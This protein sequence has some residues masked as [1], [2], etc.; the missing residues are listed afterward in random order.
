[1]STSVRSLAIA[2]VKSDVPRPTPEFLVVCRE[3]TVFKAIAA[4]IRKVNGRLNCA[5]GTGPALDYLLRRKIDGIVIDMNFPGA[6]DFI[7]R[8]RSCN[9][10][11][12]SVVFACMGALPETQCAFGA[13]ANF[14][15]HRPVIADKMAHMFTVARSMM[16]ADKRRYGRHPLMVPVELKV[17]GHATEC[18]MSN[19]SEGG[20]AIWW[21]HYLPPGTVLQFTFVLPFG[22]EIHGE[23]EIA[24]T[25]HDG[26][27]GVRFHILRNQAYTHLS[28]WITRRDF[29]VAV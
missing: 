12:S 5:S 3:G 1:M 11:R 29:K 19:L 21:L 15:I 24:W 18:T 20:M 28:H 9:S 14:V 6:L 25:A 27:T 16:V 22:G 10:N 26:L 7:R 17:K 23:G 13:G 2:P 8:V 4:A